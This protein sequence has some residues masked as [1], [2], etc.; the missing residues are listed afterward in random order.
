MEEKL[1]KLIAK[2]IEELKYNSSEL[3]KMDIIERLTLIS[4][5]YNLMSRSDYQEML[6]QPESILPTKVQKKFLK[7]FIRE[8]LVP[9]LHIFLEEDTGFK[10][11]NKL[12][13]RRIGPKVYPFSPEIVFLIAPGNVP[14]VAWTH[15]LFNILLGT[16]TLV[17]PSIGTEIW[18]DIFIDSWRSIDKRVY[19]SIKRIDLPSELAEEWLP[20]VESEIDTFI[21][22]GSD[23]TVNFIRTHLSPHTKLIYYPNKV[24]FAIIKSFYVEESLYGLAED[25]LMYNQ[26]GCLSPQ[27]LF[28]IGIPEDG[29]RELAFKLF[30]ILGNLFKDEYYI[31]TPPEDL[32]HRTRR[33]IQVMNFRAETEIYYDKSY[34]WSVIYFPRHEFRPYS[35]FNSILVTPL[36]DLEKLY[37]L[38][39]PWRGQIQAIGI[40][41]SYPHPEEVVDLAFFLRAN[42]IS[43]LGDMQLPSIYW[44]N[45]G[46]LILA[47]LI[48]IIDYDIKEKF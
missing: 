24:S 39:E 15:M 13:Y 20:L 25:I 1:K 40:N 33:L 19:N 47:P 10:E 9:N 18:V 32:I 23:E 34:N 3:R 8:P 27:Q 6:I 12:V 22:Y 46:R 28:V 17:R 44:H 5:W 41:E 48:H 45:E 2:F 42:R 37:N 30:N 16:S 14:Q 11:I 26:Q 21:V 35:A 4:R 36:K 29:V 7:N 31:P 43:N 38:M